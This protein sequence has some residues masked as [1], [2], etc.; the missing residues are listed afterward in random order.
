MKRRLTIEEA[1]IDEQ[2]WTGKGSK[3]DGVRRKLDVKIAMSG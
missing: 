2:G 1:A 3:S